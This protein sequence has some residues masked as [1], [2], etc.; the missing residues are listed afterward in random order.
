MNREHHELISKLAELIEDHE[1]N[2]SGRVSSPGK[3]LGEPLETLYFYDAFLNGDGRGN[4]EA[5]FFD[6]TEIEK[7]VFVAPPGATSY[8]V[9]ETNEGFV[10]GNYLFP[11]RSTRPTA[12]T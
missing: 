3:F 12:E 10:Y 5:T 1:W 2:P 6:L 8:M 7:Q 4:E 11:G 9:L